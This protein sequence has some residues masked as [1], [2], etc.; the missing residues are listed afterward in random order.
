A[1]WLSTWD[2]DCEH[3]IG[4]ARATESTVKSTAAGSE[5]GAQADT[6]PGLDQQMPE[7]VNE[8]P[9]KAEY[10]QPEFVNPQADSDAQAHN[11]L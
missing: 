4:G 1:K 10:V 7:A 6:Q 2:I 9:V 8:V 11:E 3:A 5:L